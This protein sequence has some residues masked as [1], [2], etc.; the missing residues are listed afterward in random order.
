M[1]HYSHTEKPP[2]SLRLKGDGITL[3][4]RT[5][6]RSLLEGADEGDPGAMREAAA[7][8]AW[9]AARH[10]KA[11]RLLDD[12]GT[13]TEALQA[14]GI[15]R[16]QGRRPKY[17]GWRVRHFYALLTR[18]GPPLPLSNGEQLERPLPLVQAVQV[19]RNRFGFPSDE[20][21]WE[22]LRDERRRGRSRTSDTRWLAIFALDYRL[23]NRA[24]LDAP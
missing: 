10:A 11:L 18:P 17:D 4:L 22:Y 16:A 9:H 19:V 1:T 8:L 6:D 12:G 20:A 3:E 24:E 15:S 23:P 13:P 5:S 21:T 7:R 14:L 2:P